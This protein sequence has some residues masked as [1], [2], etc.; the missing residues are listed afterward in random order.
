MRRSPPAM[1]C[2]LG[3][4]TRKRARDEAAAAPAPS[5]LPPALRPR[6][7]SQEAYPVGACAAADAVYWFSRDK[8]VVALGE[9]ARLELD[10]PAATVRCGVGA[11]GGAPWLLRLAGTDCVVPRPRPAHTHHFTAT[12]R[13]EE[14]ESTLIDRSAETRQSLGRERRGRGRRHRG[15]RP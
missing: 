4:D 2:L 10:V 12:T 5:L 8:G 14:R 6:A 13:V 15:L 1:R 9:R 3:L 11:F 7:I